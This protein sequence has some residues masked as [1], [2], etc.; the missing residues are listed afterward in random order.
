MAQAWLIGIVGAILGVVG[1]LLALLGWFTGCTLGAE[2]RAI[3]TTGLGIGLMLLGS[4]LRFYSK[5]SARI[6]SDDSKRDE[7]IA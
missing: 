4:Y 2:P 1:F 3:A 5:Q 6:A 7:P